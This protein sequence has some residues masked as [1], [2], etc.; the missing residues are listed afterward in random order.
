MFFRKSNAIRMETL[1]LND[2]LAH[3]MQVLVPSSFL[4]YM[5][6]MMS[7]SMPKV[8]EVSLLRLAFWV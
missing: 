7:F 3:T 4:L 6:L 2:V 8:G 1:S 5:I